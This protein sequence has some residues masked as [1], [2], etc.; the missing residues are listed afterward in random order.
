MTTM[1]GIVGIPG[2]LGSESLAGFDWNAW[3]SSSESAHWKGF[4]Q[5]AAARGLTDA[6]GKAPSV[7]TARA[8]WRRAREEVAAARQREAAANANRRVGSKPPSKLPATWRPAAFAEPSRPPPSR[9]GSS[10]AISSPRPAT[11]S[12]V[13]AVPVQ[14]TFVDPNDPPEVQQMFLDIEAQLRRADRYLGPPLKRR[15]E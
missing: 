13:A 5:E 9:G 8:T 4:C 12:A 14:G 3:P 2:R 15:T 10:P 11:P 6:T 7:E 1:A